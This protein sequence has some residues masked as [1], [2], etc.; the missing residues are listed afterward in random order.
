MNTLIRQKKS[1]K[2]KEDII[3]RKAPRSNNHKT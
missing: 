1:K 3:Q 2:Q